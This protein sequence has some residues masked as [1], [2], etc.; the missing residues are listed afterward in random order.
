MACQTG[1]GGGGRSMRRE[2]EREVALQPV[3]TAA[4]PLDTRLVVLVRT[5]CPRV[6]HY[7]VRNISLHCSCSPSSSPLCCR[8]CCLSLSLSPSV[9]GQGYSNTFC[10]GQHKL[11][12]LNCRRRRRHLGVYFVGILR[13]QVATFTAGKRRGGVSGGRTPVVALWQARQCLDA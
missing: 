5:S 7:N 6:A 12:A 13:L 8:Y 2:R 9:S 4:R 10:A 11:S 1:E 3:L